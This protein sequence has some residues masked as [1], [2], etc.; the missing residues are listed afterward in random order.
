MFGGPGDSAR[1]V[2]APTNVA[3]CYHITARSFQ[4][5]ERF[6][7]PVIVLTDFYL[8]NRVEN[9]T[10]PQLSPDDTA[11]GTIWAESSQKGSYKRYLVTDSGVS[12]M[13]IPGMEGFIF[14]ATGLEHTEK[15]IPDYSP[16]NHTAMSAKRHRKLRTALAEL[17]PPVQVPESGKFAVGVI[18]WGSTYGQVLE[19]VRM[20]RDKGLEV[21]AL[22]IVTLSPYHDEAI[23]DFMERCG[24]ILIC[25]LNFEG[26]LAN[27]I[28]HLHRKDVVRFCKVTGA[29]FPPLEILAQIEA[30][31]G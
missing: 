17:P 3:E 16:E 12:P 9:L 5:A 10:P 21:A 11:L 13:A 28:G 29:P 20:A 25:E 22:K 30:L 8:D 7:T 31:I 19:A 2:V 27:L 23:R 24:E 6:Q 18:G 4:W 1:I 15:G 14:Q 26:Q